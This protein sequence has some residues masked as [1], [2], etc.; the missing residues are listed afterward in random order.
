I[1]IENQSENDGLQIFF[2]GSYD[3]YAASIEAETAIFYTTTSGAPNLFVNLT[4]AISPVIIP[5][6]GGAIDYN[7]QVGNNG[8]SA[9]NADIWCDVTLP[10]GLHYGPTLGPIVGFNFPASWTTNRNRVQNV[11]AGARPGEYSLNGYIGIYPA[12]VYQQ[13]SFPFT[14]T[15]AIGS[16]W[17]TGWDN[18]GEPFLQNDLTD[19]EVLPVSFAL[20]QSFPNPFN[21][22]TTIIF[23]MPEAARVDLSVYDISGRKVV[24]LVN[25][26]REAGAYTVSFDGSGLPSGIYFARLN[27]GEYAVVQKLVLLK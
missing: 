13:D 5:P 10:T 2:D 19:L 25:G 14:K 17:E 27:A 11:P 22:I 26:W 8:S 16:D 3:V 9:E 6:E 24:E 21:P 23:T 12:T 4:P 20:K 18:T 15:G 7:I 1:G